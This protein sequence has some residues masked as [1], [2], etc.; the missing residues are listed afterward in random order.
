MVN[1]TYIKRRQGLGKIFNVGIILYIH[2][3]THIL[4]YKEKNLERMNQNVQ[5]GYFWLVESEPF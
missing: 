2:A 5:G 1:K 4:S 3:Y